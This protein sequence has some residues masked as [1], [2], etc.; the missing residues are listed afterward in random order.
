MAELR[1]E[2]EQVEAIKNWWQENGKS[3]VVALALVVS[4]VFGWR[5]WQSNQDASAATA[6]ALY[7]SLSASVE[8]VQE[9]DDVQ[10]ASMNHLGKQLK[11]DF[12]S[13]AYAPMAAMV[14]ARVYVEQGDLVAAQN[15]LEY[16]ISSEQARPTLIELAKLRKIQILLSQSELDAAA[17][18]LASINEITY[19]SLFY[20]LSGDL[21]YAQG[22]AAKA[23]DAYRLAMESSDPQT[24]SLIQLKYD[25]LASGDS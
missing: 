11:D 20:E 14:L 19:S 9:L 5:A 15:E 18:L 3:L 22:D 16:V 8:A 6:S 13:S 12:G 23:R 17:T 7:E 2:E 10:V 4:A 1:T 21:S 24:R 25:D